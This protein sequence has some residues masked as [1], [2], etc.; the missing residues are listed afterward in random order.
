MNE[1]DFLNQLW[2]DKS[3][4]ESNKSELGEHGDVGLDTFYDLQKINQ[5]LPRNINKE[6]KELIEEYYDDLLSSMNRYVA[7]I[8]DYNV[9][10]YEGIDPQDMQDLDESRRRMHDG[11]ITIL[12]VLARLHKKVGLDNSWRNSIGYNRNQ[13]RQWA[14]LVMNH[15]T[16]QKERE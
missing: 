2:S 14:Q 7:S 1:R 13:V 11:L 12:D 6:D 4:G 5:N 10:K 9:G 8:E 15:L 16:S 3:G